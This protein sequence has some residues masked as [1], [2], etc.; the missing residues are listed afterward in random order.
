MSSVSNSPGKFEAQCESQEEGPDNLRLALDTLQTSLEGE[1]SQ[2]TNLPTL[3][4][5]IQ[6][7]GTGVRMRPSS[8]CTPPLVHSRF[9]QCSVA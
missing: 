6:M 7:L 2:R 8:G 3:P 9:R 1:L 4:S 5:S